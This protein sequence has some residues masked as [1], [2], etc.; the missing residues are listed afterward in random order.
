MQNGHANDWDMRAVMMT[1]DDLLQKA[2][3][4]NKTSGFVCPLQCTLD[5]ALNSTITGIAPNQHKFIFRLFFTQALM[6]DP[7]LIPE[8]GYSYERK[9]I[10]VWLDSHMLAPH[11]RYVE[12]LL[13][14]MPRP[15]LCQTYTD[16]C[17]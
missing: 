13:S 9:Y 15:Y 8:S 3:S 10:E 7:V 12:R 6:Q 14:G 17:E 2:T 5:V 16:D 4:V 11:S 1:S